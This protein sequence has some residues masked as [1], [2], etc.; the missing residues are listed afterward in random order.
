MQHSGST[1]PKVR[2]SR[3]PLVGVTIAS[4]HFLGSHVPEAACFGIAK[5]GTI[6]LKVEPPK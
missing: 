4:G 6:G 1:R 5:T 2:K 3:K